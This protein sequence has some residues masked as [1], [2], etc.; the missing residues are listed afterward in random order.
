MAMTRRMLLA[1]PGLALAPRARADAPFAGADLLIVAMADLHSAMERAAA[2]LGAVDAALSAN[3]G[4]PAVIAI[5]GDVFERGNAVALR[6]GGAADWAFLAALRRRAPVVLNLG[7]HETALLDDMAEAVRR[8]E[9]LDLRVVSNLRDRRTGLP[10]APAVATFPLPGGRRLVLAGIATD[11]AMTYRQVARSALDIPPPAEWAR[12]NLPG[13][14][15]GA[16]ARVVLSHAGVAADRAILPLLPDGTLLLGG[17]EHLRFHHRAGATRYLHGGSWNRFVT[18]AAFGLG[19][20]TPELATREVAIEPG[21]AEDAAHAALVREVLAAQLSA[22]EREVL[23]SLPRAMP[24]GEA[25]RRASAAIAM[26]TGTATGLIGHTTFGTGLP[27]GE[28]TRFAFDACIRFD[29]PL[30]RAEA[31]AALLAAMAPRLNQDGDLPLQDR[32]GD[33]AYAHALPAGPS[34]LSAIGWVRQNAAR[35]LGTDALRFEP[36]PGATLKSATIEALRR[37]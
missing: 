35:F 5:N 21:L 33:F 13:L 22:A 4:V 19:R 11:E 25:A 16:E 10:F 2:V 14:L 6:S 9:A 12:E 36:A 3:R 18:L 37:L 28:V 29:G 8:A 27:A 31:D 24:L 7:N 34:V 17:H 23:F 1:M 32:I 26:A 20:E 15:A 30:F